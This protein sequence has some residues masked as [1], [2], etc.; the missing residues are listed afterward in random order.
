M[1]MKESS[2]EGHEYGGNHVVLDKTTE[3]SSILGY[4]VLPVGRDWGARRVRTLTPPPLT[5]VV[6]L[7]ACQL[8]L[9]EMSVHL[10]AIKVSIVALAVGIM[11][12][13]CLFSRED[14]GLWEGGRDGREERFQLTL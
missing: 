10:V 3:R 13:H 14:T 2:S 4:Q 5:N 7:G 11:E 8:V 9:R 12:S 6:G 1:A